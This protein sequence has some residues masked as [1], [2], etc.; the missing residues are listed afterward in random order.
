MKIQIMMFTNKDHKKST[1]YN[2][3][4]NKDHCHYK[5]PFINKTIFKII[6]TWFI[7][8]AKFHNQIFT[9]SVNPY[10]C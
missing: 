10:N 2:Q 7:N 4:T 6:P 5:R 1:I 8:R 3:T 9:L